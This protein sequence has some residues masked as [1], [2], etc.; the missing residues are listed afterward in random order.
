M[1]SVARVGYTAIGPF[2]RLTPPPNFTIYIPDPAIEGISFIDVRSLTRIL[3]EVEADQPVSV[4]VEN[5]PTGAV[6]DSKQLARFRIDV[7]SFDP[8]R[9]NTIGLDG[10]DANVGFIRLRITTGPTAPS[11][12]GVWVEAKR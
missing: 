10:P 5:S 12:I 3:I 2:V 11:A 1:S 8:A 4:E 6:A 9:R 7:A